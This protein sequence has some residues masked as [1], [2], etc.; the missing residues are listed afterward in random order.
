MAAG[1]SATPDFMLKL[2]KEIAVNYTDPD[3][4]Y[5][6]DMFNA[7][8]KTDAYVWQDEVR[9]DKASWIPGTSVETPGQWVK[10]SKQK[11]TT[12]VKTLRAQAKEAI[13][14]GDFNTDAIKEQFKSLT[15][16]DY[17]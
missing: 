17:D 3:T 1:K 10:Q 2:E 16:Q 8:S 6:V 5:A 15:G 13:D 11:T 9:V 12:D 14:S 4:L 7:N